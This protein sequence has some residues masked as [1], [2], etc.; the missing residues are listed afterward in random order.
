MRSGDRGGERR[1]D[2]CERNNETCII[3]LMKREKELPVSAAPFY[4]MFFEIRHKSISYLIS[5]FLLLEFQEKDRQHNRHEFRHDDG[6]PD[7]VD[8]EEKRQNDNI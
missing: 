4:K 3:R 1:R 5:I 8:T 2:I 6:D 7:P